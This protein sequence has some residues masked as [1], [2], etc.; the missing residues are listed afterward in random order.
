[1]SGTPSFES[2]LT[3]DLPTIAAVA[4]ATAIYM[5]GGSRRAAALAGIDPYTEAYVSWSRGQLINAV[6]QLFQHGIQ[7]V[8]TAA[9]VPSN[10]AE[11][12]AFHKMLANYAQ[13]VVAGPES[14]SDYAQ[15]GWRVR[16]LGGADLPSLINTDSYLQQMTRHHTG[17]TLWWMIVLDDD[18]PYRWMFETANRNQV[19]TRGEVIQALYGEHVP[20]AD[21]FIASGKPMVTPALVPPLLVGNLQCYWVQR[22][23]YYLPPHL[24]RAI[25][26]DSVYSRHTWRSDKQ[27]R[28][29][30]AL[31]YRDVWEREVVVGL[32][33]RL[34]AHWYPL[35]WH[36]EST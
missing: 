4:P 32:G 3:A 19:T 26:Y 27:G 16:I 22:P 1:M 25:L 34:G 14:I 9:I 7:H 11:D 15:R 36:E 6:E 29:E 12:D 35:C 5:P 13:W 23:G 10:W 21:L 24:L 18:A 17:P 28:A 2:F 20:P 8:F 31:T 30:T 33:H